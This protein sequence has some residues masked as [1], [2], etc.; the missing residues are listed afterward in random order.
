MKDHMH[1]TNKWMLS[2]RTM[3]MM[4]NN[5]YSGNQSISTSSEMRMFN[6]MIGVM[7]GLNKAITLSAMLPFH[8]KE[9]RMS[10]MGG[11]QSKITNDGLGDF[12]LSAISLLQ[13][14]KHNSWIIHGGVS[15]P[16]GKFDKKNQM[17]MLL[18]QGMQL[19]SGTVDV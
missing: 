7:Y 14:T 15:L 16:T 9:M 11:P 17:G 8:N 19:G 18:E 12:K 3:P 13:Q 6:T 1:S 10:M 4:M 5:E 2:V